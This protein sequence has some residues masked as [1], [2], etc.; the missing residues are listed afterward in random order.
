MSEV[1][2]ELIE[3][4]NEKYGQVLNLRPHLLTARAEQYTTAIHDAGAP[5]DCCVGFIDC[6]RIRMTRPGGHNS[7]QRNV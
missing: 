7:I 3:K 1:F 6:T 2:W 5:L 4:C